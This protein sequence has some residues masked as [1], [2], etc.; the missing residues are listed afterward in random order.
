MK[1]TLTSPRIRRG[2]AWLV[3][4]TMTLTQ[5]TQVAALTLATVPLAATTTTVVRPN[6]MYVLDDSGSMGWDYTPD[7]INDATITDPLNA[8][9]GPAGSSGDTGQV[10]LTGGSVSAITAVGANSYYEQPAVVIE[11]GGGVGAAATATWN[12]STKKITAV[13]VTAG[14][15][16]YTSKP[17]VTFV[18]K[19]ASAAWGM[20]WGTTGAS[21]QGGTPKDT[22]ASPQCTTP[23]QIP[24]AAAPVNYQYYDPAVHYEVPR[25]AAWNSSCSAGSAT[26]Y[27][28][29]STPTAASSDGFLGGTTKN[30]TNVWTHEVWCNVSTAVPSAADPTAA[31]KCR[32]NLDSSGDILY[33]NVTF[34]F[35]KTYNGPAFYYTMGPS[36]YCTDDN[37]TSC[38]RS[39][40][41]TVVG[42]TVFNVPSKYRWCAYYNP[43]S[44]AFGGCQGRRDWS[45]YI[46]NYLGGWVST[47]A[48]GVQAT[49]NLTINSVPIFPATQ[50]MTG[51]TIGG[52]DVIGGTTITTDAASTTATVAQQV[53]AA[54]LAQTSST[55]Y[56]CA[57]G[58]GNVLIQAVMVGTVANGLQVLASGPPDAAAINSTGVLVVTGAKSGYQIDNISI[59]HTDGSGTA[60]LVNG[61]VVATANC[62]TYLTSSGSVN[63][64]LDCGSQS[65]LVCEAINSGPG[66]GLYIA[67]SGDNSTGV[68]G[69]P[70]G[71]CNNHVDGTVYLLR[72]P[73]D[74]AD[75]NAPIVVSGPA[76]ATLSTGT[77]TVNATLDATRLADITVSGFGSII[78]SSKPL[79]YADGTQTSAIAADIASKIN[80]DTGTSGCTATAALN[81]VS[82]SGS[83]ACTG[84]L[85]YTPVGS[86]ATGTFRVST[87]GSTNA[88]SLGGIQVNTANLVGVLTSANITNGTAV[89]TNAGT[90]RTQ[91]NN[92][93]GVLSNGV[94]P[95]GFTAAA[96]VAA[97]GGNY[98]VTVTAPAG[99][100][101]NGMSFTFLGGTA[102]A[103]GAGSQPQ[104]TF[105]ITGASADNAPLTSITCGGTT[106]VGARNTGSTSAAA[107]Y[108][109]NLTVNTAAPT[110]GLHGKTDAGGLGYG[111]SCSALAAPA[112]R[113]TVTGPAGAAACANLSISKDASISLSTTTPATIGGSGSSKSWEITFN[114]ATT[115][116]RD[117]TS[118]RCGT[119]SSDPQMLNSD[120]TI[121]SATA[122]DYAS[123][124]ASAINT[125]SSNQNG[126]NGTSG[127]S[128]S[129]TTVSCD[130]ER[131]SGAGNR[132]GSVTVTKSG[133]TLTP[134]SVSESWNGTR[135]I[136]SF[137]ITN[138]TAGA[139]GISSVTC[140]N[141]GN[142]EAMSS[143]AT[144]QSGD[145]TSQFADRINTA[146]NNQNGWNGN[147]GCFRVNTGHIRCT[148]ER[149]AGVGN[150]C[151]GGVTQSGS[152]VT[153]GSVTETLSGTQYKYT[154]DITN[155]GETN[156]KVSSV[157]CTTPITTT[158][159]S[160][161][162]LASTGVA[163][164]STVVQRLNM[165]KAD[166]HGQNDGTFAWS[167]PTAATNGSPTLTCTA[168][169]TTSTCTSTNLR[170]RGD[171]Q[172]GVYIAGSASQ[173]DDTANVYAATY[174]ATGGSAPSWVFDIT[175]A[176]ADSAS[177]SAISCGGTS[178][179]PANA[180][181][182][183]TAPASTG[184][185]RINNLT[186]SNGVANGTVGPT[187]GYTLVCQPATA[188]APTPSCTLTGPVGLGA[189]NGA[190]L[191]FNKDSSIAIGGVS[192]TNGSA[193]STATDNFYVSDGNAL[194]TVAPFSTGR[195]AQGA[196]AFGFANVDVGPVS[197]TTFNMSDG[198]ASAASAIQTN[199]TGALTMSG[200]QDP[201]TTTNHWTDV[202]VFKRVDLVA[203]NNS[204]SRASGRSDCI[205][206]TCTYNEEMQNFANWYT[207]YRTRMQMMKSATSI[208]FSE[209]DG[210]YRIGF[211]N[212][213]QATGTTVKR[214]V[215]Q[216]LDVGETPN[217]RTDWWNN[218]TTSSPACATPLR[219]ETAKIG[220]YYAGKVVASGDPLQYSCQQNFMML[221][222]DGY[223]NENEPAA[224]S[225]LGADIGNTD[226]NIA[227]APRPYYD[228]AQSSPRRSAPAA[229]AAPPPVPT[230]PWPISP[231]ITTRPICVHRRGRCSS[232]RAPIMA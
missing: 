89:S 202:G 117:I 39:T 70:W 108:V 29:A 219:A 173:I 96:P 175:N 15:S 36:E 157:I 121:G 90:L 141:G 61:P 101:Y 200:G 197:I 51:L 135:Y 18:G 75:D 114:N 187:N 182:T 164:T 34:T 71:T 84:T 132:C 68:T 103:G 160:M 92:G 11:G 131:N 118:I 195:L 178:I 83:G 47:G 159:E 7:Y 76:A 46:P 177:I 213:C 54:I 9:T 16:G 184:Y 30:L 111:Y 116:N 57:A 79:L 228:G 78:V 190:T 14:G 208:A 53:C 8:G 59:T 216:F 166:L 74:D 194:S 143:T 176:T 62:G 93:T 72:I 199:A 142:Q 23:T 205:G 52:V 97:A 60:Q 128:S 63:T 104:W 155:A 49:A 134:G 28:P 22:N 109:Q 87:T 138:V 181:N 221:V 154:F 151:T 115:D 147:S 163:G 3:M 120:I 12:S 69:L 1:T 186:G 227:T 232:P 158:Q 119:T 35:R 17:F 222:T 81:V 40:A 37:L 122:T 211:D 209:L 106:A 64:G 95:H 19:L 220:R 73:A 94:G 6:L 99:N 110:Y 42:P 230:A 130:F 212:I 171:N 88:A 102:G 85:T 133:T 225:I 38:V 113:C 170:F 214:K 100:S 150:R 91:V 231:S 105:P 167:C 58:G 203:T 161:A 172:T 21:N 4:V 10:T 196:T 50:S 179:L 86:S 165:I 191:T 192:F 27:Y 198:T 217:H 32:E 144:R 189:C 174:T 26:C 139:E 41:P 168:T 98:D 169:S 146:S 207:Y 156:D 201:D 126:W 25:K 218:L 224:T 188:T 180:P 55:G 24:Y 140:N 45:H 223:W 226:N 31:G 137:D 13:T 215:G 145:D 129:G 229:D 82:I 162:A 56:S 66:V 127:C 183:G 5:T 112:Y 136:Y 65:K 125:Q 107:N 152:G 148:F 153:F 48:A 20:C 44:H 67:R 204:Y 33:P 210:K 206:A 149:D 123:N 185:Q 80:V 193:T 77:I 43:Q 2:I 124:L